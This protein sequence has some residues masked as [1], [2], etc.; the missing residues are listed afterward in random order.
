MGEER[1]RTPRYPFIAWAQVVDSQ[2]GAS[3]SARVSELSLYGCY[4]DMEQP[5]P[6]GTSILVKISSGERCFEAPGKI[7][8]STPHLGVGVCFEGVERSS[9]I[10]LKE[11][12]VMAAKTKYGVQL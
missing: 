2:S 7:V 8:Y 11:W 9:L 6:R 10:V 3:I 4:I 12:L 5:L 1:R